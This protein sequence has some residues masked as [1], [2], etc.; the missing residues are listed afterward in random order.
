MKAQYWLAWG[1]TRVISR[2]I[3]RADVSGVENLPQSGGFLLACNHISLADPPL[4][5][6]WVPREMYFLARKSLFDYWGL[7]W[8]IRHLN[9]LPLRR[10]AVD[11]RA[12][13][14]G[15]QVIRQGHGLIVF[16]EGTRSKSGR[17]LE[18]RSGVGMIAREAACPVVP[19]YVYGAESLSRCLV[20]RRRLGLTFGS[21]LSAAW[22]ASFPSAKS[23]YRALTE[24]IMQRIHGLKE[25]EDG[26]RTAAK[27]D[28]CRPG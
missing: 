26:R 8:L 1:L 3:F 19:A 17:L 22:V 27:P 6:C 14:L 20:G 23:G 18:G 16:P 9:A 24:E 25:A 4:V 5:G 15:I 11:R 10:D 2:Y 7:G 28:S 13:E 12:L 21:P